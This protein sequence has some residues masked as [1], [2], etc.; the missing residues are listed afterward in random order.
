M[1]K[2]VF[3]PTGT[4]SGEIKL[5]EIRETFALESMIISVGMSLTRPCVMNESSVSCMLRMSVSLSSV[6]LDESCSIRL[7]GLSELLLL[8][9]CDCCG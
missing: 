1:P 9:G 4:I 7:T 3:E 2:S 6:G 8:T 5:L